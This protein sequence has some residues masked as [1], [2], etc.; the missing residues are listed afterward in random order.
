MKLNRTLFVLL[1]AS[2]LIA[3][4]SGCASRPLL[5]DV[6]VRPQVIS[7]NADGQTDVARI[8]YR[9]SRSAD[10]SIY[11]VDSEGQRHY[12]RQDRRR[13]AGKYQ[14]DFGGVIEG[15][16]LP[17]GE[18]TYVV[19]ATDLSGHTERVEGHLTLVDA[20]TTPPEL[21]NFSV[22]PHTF[23]PNQDGFDDRV[24]IE[25]YL[26]KEAKV[27]VFLIAPDGTKYPIAEKERKV[28]PG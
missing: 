26:T 7:P 15:R 25:Y 12:F 14:V 28:K 21:R 4:S 1:V 18:Y 13:S 27:Q 2:A 3:L 8:S 5:Y 24:T 6:N 16:M 9:L 10:L 23:T 17:D 20:D 22:Y 19:E 11:F